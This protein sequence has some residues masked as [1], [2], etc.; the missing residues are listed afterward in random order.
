MTGE[1]DAISVSVKPL[2]Q[3]M[4]AVT[5]LAAGRRLRSLHGPSTL[6][7]SA[8][9]AEG[10]VVGSAFVRQIEQHASSPDLEQ[11][12]ETFTRALKEPLLV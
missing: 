10:V 11:R 2:I 1:Q 9:V 8:K 3:A 4:R 6:P 7:Q 12:L 5:K